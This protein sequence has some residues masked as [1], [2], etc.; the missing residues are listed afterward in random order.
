MIV[1]NFILLLISLSKLIDT[2]SGVSPRN[3]H[4]SS[5]ITSQRSLVSYNIED[6]KAF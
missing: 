2:G 4:N 6:T 5:C 3:I 1:L